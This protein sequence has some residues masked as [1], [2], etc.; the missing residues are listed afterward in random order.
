MDEQS[1]EPTVPEKVGN[2]RAVVLEIC[3]ASKAVE[4]RKAA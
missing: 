1:Y 3:R 2:R 4:L